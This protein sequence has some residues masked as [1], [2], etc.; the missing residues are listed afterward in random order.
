[1]YILTEQVLYLTE[2]QTF[3][4]KLYG[5]LTE[6][7]KQKHRVMPFY[8]KCMLNIKELSMAVT[9]YLENREPTRPV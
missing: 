5:L 3:V 6:E 1:M 2:T 4:V 8:R 7:H 9:K